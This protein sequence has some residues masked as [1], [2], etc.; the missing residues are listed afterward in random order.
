MITKRPRGGRFRR[1]ALSGSIASLLLVAGCSSTDVDPDGGAST[2]APIEVTSTDLAPT[3]SSIVAPTESSTPA[4]VESTVDSPELVPTTIETEVT[5]STV[6]AATAD[7]IDTSGPD[8]DQAITADTIVVTLGGGPGPEQSTTVFD[9][10][11]PSQT[12]LPNKGAAVLVPADGSAIPTA[13]T[14]TVSRIYLAAL[15]HDYR[16]LRAILGDSRFRYGPLGEGKTVDRWKEE[17]TEGRDPLARVVRL[18]EYAPGVSPK[19]TIVWPYVAVK[20]PATWDAADEA[21]LRELGF[22]DAQ[23]AATRI[24]GRYLDDRL[25]FELDGTWTGFVNGA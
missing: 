6:D 14:D 24:K 11:G 9:S 20:D 18:L 15:R 4:S 25:T 22:N 8:G 10:E 16:D 1:A 23:I 21:V 2:S 13:V 3:E 17:V 12:T 5:L 7:T 19:G